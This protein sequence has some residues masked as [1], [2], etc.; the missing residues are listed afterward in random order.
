MDAE[1]LR[2]E[3]RARARRRAAGLEARRA[4]RWKRA[5]RSRGPARFTA[6]FATAR[7]CATSPRCE[8]ALAS[9]RRD[10]VDARSAR[11]LSRRG[12]RAAARPPVRPHAGRAQPALRQAGRDSGRLVAA[13][14]DPQAVRGGWRRSRAS[15]RNHLRLGR[16]RRGA[17]LRARQSSARTTSRSMTAPGPNGV[18]ARTPPS[19]RDRH[20]RCGPSRPSS[21]I[22]RCDAPPRAPAADADGAAACAD[23]GGEDPAP[24]LPLS[25]RSRRRQLALGRAPACSTTRRL[26]RRSIGT[27]SRSSC[28]TRTARRPAITSSISA[29]P[30]A[31]NLV[32]FGLMPE[33]TGMRDRALA[34]RLRR[35]RKLSRAAP[36]R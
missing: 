25:L 34:A 1:G 22:W 29:S 9:R 21:P 18:R 3:G 35:Q 17:A 16:D 6:T 11:A 2:R 30:T 14:E 10:V 5:R 19:P 26:R 4:I 31:T 32:Y 12:A 27:A 28:S 33:W 23:E 7:R 8:R 15:R 24:L 20:E 13:G 36:R